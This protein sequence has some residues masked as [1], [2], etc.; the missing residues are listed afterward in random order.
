MSDTEPG[1]ATPKTTLRWYRFSLRSLLLFTFAVALLAG[2]ISWAWRTNRETT[3]RE[4]LL[5]LYRGLNVFY[6]GPHLFPPLYTTDQ[7]G[8]PM[9]SCALT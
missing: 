7:A 5:R 8:R 1:L 2:A 9:H 3:C 6:V 4:H